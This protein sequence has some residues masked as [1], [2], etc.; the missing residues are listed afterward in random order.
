MTDDD[1]ARRERIRQLSADIGERDRELFDRLAQG[2]DAP[3]RTRTC[4]HCG[5]TD[6]GTYEAGY[7]GIN[8][9]ALCHPNVSDRP[10]C[11]RLVTL[12]KHAMPCRCESLFP[13]AGSVDAAR[14]RQPHP[15]D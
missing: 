5:R 6:V 10:D 13:A 11:F 4:G 7:G 14:G 8:D 1:T 2:P 12:Y 15:A 3:S 9:I